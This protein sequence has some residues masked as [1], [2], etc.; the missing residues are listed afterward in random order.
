M[1]AK[2]EKING[3]QLAP[4]LLFLHST[5]NQE[6][7]P[8][9]TAGLPIARLKSITPESQADTTTYGIT[10]DIL[11]WL[12]KGSG[13]ESLRV[14]PKYLLRIYEIVG[15]DPDQVGIKDGS[16]L[17]PELQ[18]L[19]PRFDPL[20]NTKIPF[21][22]THILTDGVVAKAGLTLTHSL[23]RK[24]LANLEWLRLGSD[25][26]YMLIQLLNR[27]RETYPK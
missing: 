20:F 17:S 3:G 14:N 10:L 11:E 7:I 4:L 25:N 13:D 2:F 16:V 1:I 12:P 23:V 19:V 18:E 26:T 15:E 21:D 22:I 5:N 27:L 6:T 24:L 8:M 9:R